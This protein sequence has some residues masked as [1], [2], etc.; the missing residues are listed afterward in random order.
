MIYSVLSIRIVLDFTFPFMK[1]FPHSCKHMKINFVFVA[2]VSTTW[3]G[4]SDFLG[5]ELRTG[6]NFEAILI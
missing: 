5:K 6:D 3:F 2:F 1:M 4:F